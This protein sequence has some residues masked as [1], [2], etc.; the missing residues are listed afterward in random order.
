MNSHSGRRRLAA[1]AVVSAVVAVACGGSSKSPKQQAGQAATSTTLGSDVTTSSVPGETTTVPQVTAAGVARSTTTAAVAT[2]KATSSSSAAKPSGANN[3]TT[4][5]TAAPSI[6]NVNSSPQTTAAS[7]ETPKPGGSL[8]YVYYNEAISLDPIKQNWASA[9]LQDGIRAFPIFDTLL[10]QDPTNGSLSTETAQSL[11]STDAL[12]WQLKVKPNIKFSDGTAYDASAIRFNWLR[13]ADPAN[14]SPYASVAQS[15]QSLTVADPLTLNI[16]LKTRNGQFPRSVARF[17]G[18]IGSPTAIQSMGTAY[19]SSPVAAGPFLVKEWVRDDHLTLVRNPTYWNAPRP[20]LDSITLKLVIN[21]AQRYDT[22]KTGGGDAMLAAANDL[23]AY[24]Q[25]VK[26]GFPVAKTVLSGGRNIYLNT[27]KPP[28]D[29]IRARRAV[30]LGLDRNGYSQALE[31]GQGIIVDNLF[32]DASPFYDPSL[33]LP[34]YDPAAAQK[35]IDAYVADHGGT[36]LTFTILSNPTAAAQLQWFQG[37]LAQYKNIKVDIETVA[38]AQYT[39]RQLSG[40]YQFAIAATTPLDPEPAL[41][42]AFYSTGAK[43]FERYSNADLDKALDAG[44][45][46]LDPAA[47][48][49]AY[50][51]A[52]QIIIDQVPVVFYTRLQIFQFL[53][54]K[55][56]N[57]QMFEDAT[58]RFDG[59]WLK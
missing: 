55:V 49:A 52:Q 41:Y 39:P 15:M 57:W 58:P 7:G 32:T 42:D 12:N 18:F 2:K 28:F 46:A 3:L 51:T 35:Q 43:N 19:A 14:G 48:V 16:T 31:H 11:T 23:D 13:A 9:V 50:K 38:N 40:D 22:F 36:P 1:I 10:M 53:Q 47:R 59:V 17:L 54:A 5:V 45:S 33:K 25:A 29:D 30:A 6:A 20:Y 24:V 8:T 26:D 34:T 21:A 4:K 27:S 44:R 56:Q 37:A